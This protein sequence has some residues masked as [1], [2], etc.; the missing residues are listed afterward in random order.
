MARGEWDDTRRDA[1]EAL[2]A[3]R[4][5]EVARRFAAS[6]LDRVVKPVA[7]AFLEAEPDLAVP[8][9]A[10]VASRRGQAAD[11]AGALLVALDGAHPGLV[12]RHLECTRAS[13]LRLRRR[14]TPPV[15]SSNSRTR[16]C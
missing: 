16:P 15:Q 2:A 13:S 7:V 5:P 9:L 3:I 10:D 8:A 12:D 14:G 11:T 6:L 1:A 4:A